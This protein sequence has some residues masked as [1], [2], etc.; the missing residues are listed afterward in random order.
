MKIFIWGS[1]CSRD[2]FNFP[3]TS[4]FQVV[5]Y[6]ARHSCVSAMS[7]PVKLK[8]IN[9]NSLK[10]VFKQRVIVDDFSKTLLQ[11]LKNLEYD[12]LLIDFIDERFPLKKY[13]DG[14][15]TVSSELQE[16][17]S[18]ELDESLIYVGSEERFSLWYKAWNA[19]IDFCIKYNIKDKIIIN[20]LYWAQV[21][22]KTAFSTSYISKNNAFL[23][24]IYDT[25]S[26]Y[27]PKYR[28]IDYHKNLIVSK[29]DHR[30]GI[31]PSITKMHYIGMHTL[32]YNK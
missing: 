26:M 21:D 27:I 20:R 25:V 23:K 22:K 32:H 13:D 1:C 11:D 18:V 30:W 6:H 28:H 24:R 3:L 4:H 12:I 17:Q 19:F 31:A 8:N 10:S 15:I 5:S 9:L 14:V 2:I 16:T 29:Q 7:S